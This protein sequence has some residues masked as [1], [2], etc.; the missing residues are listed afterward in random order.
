MRLTT[1][2]NHFNFLIGIILSFSVL[3]C[4]DKKKEEPGAESFASAH[5]TIGNGIDFDFN[6]G[7]AT[8]I[9]AFDTKLGIGFLDSEKGISMYLS[10]NAPKRLTEGTYSLQVKEAIK[11]AG[12]AAYLTLSP[13]TSDLFPDAFDTKKDLDGDFWNDGTGSITITSL[14]GKWIEGTFSA[15]A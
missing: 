12:A 6:G 7:N 5:V 4:S 8:T 9:S 1:S 2:R 13:I 14:K 11:N 10:V 3:S 15:V